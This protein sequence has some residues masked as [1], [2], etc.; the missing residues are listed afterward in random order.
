MSRNFKYWFAGLCLVL[1]TAG[2]CVRLALARH[3]C[4]VCAQGESVCVQV[5]NLRE[6][7]RLLA[8]EARDSFVF[9]VFFPFCLMA[10]SLLHLAGRAPSLILWKARMNH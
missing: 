9:A 5:A 6:A 3:D 2:P 7:V 4:V 10:A 1:L 8:S